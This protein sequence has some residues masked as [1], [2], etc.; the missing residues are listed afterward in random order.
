[1]SFSTVDAVIGGNNCRL[2]IPSSYTQYAC[3]YWHSSGGDQNEWSANNGST[4]A[5]Q[6]CFDMMNTDGYIVA[7]SNASSGNNWGNQASLD[8]NEALRAYMVT[9][10]APTKM[11][12]CGVSMGGIGSLLQA[13]AG[14]T[15]LA[16][17]WGIAP[18][19]NL[20]HLYNS[21][22]FASLIDSAYNI[23]G[24]GTYAAQTA[25]HDPCLLS[26]T[27]FNYLPMHYWASSADTTVSKAFNSDVMSSNVG[28]NHIENIVTPC[29]GGHGA[30]D[31]YR[32]VEL[33]GFLSRCFIPRTIAGKTV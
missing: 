1:M 6:A 2:I 13:A 23:P 19:C 9:H 16:G 5:R 21:E 20:A 28:N 27:P 29:T 18:A 12:A 26:A 32:A 4:A 11:V 8:A 17:W 15:G 10:Y 14:F 24:G 30:D 3:I 25:G 22:G 31:Q 33:S 7:C